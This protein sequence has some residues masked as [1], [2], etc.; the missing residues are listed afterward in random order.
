MSKFLSVLVLLVCV[1]FN[2]LDATASHGQHHSNGND[3][4]GYFHHIG[5][6][7]SHDAEDEQQFSV[8]YSQAAFEHSDPHAE[9]G[10][11]AL[12]TEISGVAQQGPALFDG[13]MVVPNWDPPYLEDIPPPPKA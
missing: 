8:D 5:Q 11:V 7:H 2:A 1:A 6:P 3:I 10:M 13:P 4:H 9:V 12:I